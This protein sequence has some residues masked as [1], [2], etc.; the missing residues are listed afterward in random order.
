MRRSWILSL[1]CFREIRTKS[2]VA[3]LEIWQCRFHEIMEFVSLEYRE[4]HFFISQNSFKIN[5]VALID[6]LKFCYLDSM[7]I[8]EGLFP[9][10]P[11]SHESIFIFRF[12]NFQF[13]T[14]LPQVHS[15]KFDVF[16]D[17]KDFAIRPP[18]YAH[19]MKFEGFENHL[20]VLSEMWQ[21]RIIRNQ[22]FR[23][24]TANIEA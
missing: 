10:P 23:W 18:P 24:I 12:T 11:K 7:K 14:N 4:G 5:M 20:M 21:R 19:F 13:I 3:K 16:L 6:W 9:K 1:L 15:K 8:V 22:S 17:L 2:E